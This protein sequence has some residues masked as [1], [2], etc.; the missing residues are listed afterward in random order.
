[1]TQ[2]VYVHTVKN[3]LIQVNPKVRLP[4]TFKRFSGL[5]VQLLKKLSIRATNGPE[6]L[7]QVGARD[8]GRRKGLP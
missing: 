5:M 6:K 3:A 8:V 2:A 1:V 4:R 7:L